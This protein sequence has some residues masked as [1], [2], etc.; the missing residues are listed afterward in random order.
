MAIETTILLGA[1]ADAVMTADLAHGIHGRRSEATESRY[2]AE[3]NALAVAFDV[4]GPD[5]AEAESGA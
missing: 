5:L 4:E 3:R 1:C 2:A